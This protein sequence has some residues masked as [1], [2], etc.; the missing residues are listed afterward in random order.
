[1]D[2]FFREMEVNGIDRQKGSEWAGIDFEIDY[3]CY[4]KFDSGEELSKHLENCGFR[5]MTWENMACNA[6]FS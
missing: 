4:V 1:M 6:V 5:P 2:D 3:H